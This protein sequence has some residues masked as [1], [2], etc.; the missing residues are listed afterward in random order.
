MRHADAWLEPIL[1]SQRLVVLMTNRVNVAHVGM[2]GEY[3]VLAQLAHR[4]L[5]GAL[6]LGTTKGVDILA[7]DM[8]QV[9]HFKKIEVKT[10]SKKPGRSKLFG[11]ERFYSWMMGPKHERMKDP[12]LFYCFVV[13]RDANHRPLFY[14]VPSAKVASYVTREHARWV[15]SRHG[16]DT[17]PNRRTFRIPIS[18]PDCYEEAWEQ[19]FC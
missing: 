2:A 14:I 4:G 18:D 11:D 10:T 17:S 7:T 12:D 16:R 3:Y 1:S 13:L 8:V 19:L 6:T 9:G 15:A 5:L